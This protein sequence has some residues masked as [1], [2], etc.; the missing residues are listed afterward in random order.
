MNISV[1][2]IGNMGRAVA[3]ALLSA[4]HRVTVFNRSID[5]AR[6]LEKH[7]A[8]VASSAAD[9]VRRSDHI[10]LVLA[11]GASTRSVL[12]D[13]EVVVALF[14]KALITGAGTEPDLLMSLAEGVRAAGA[15]LSDILIV[16]YPQDVEAREA[17]YC[18]S[19]CSE[20]LADWKQ[21]FS[22]IGSRVMD[23]G[24]VGNA[25]RVQTSIRYSFIHMMIA[26]GSAAAAFERQNLPLEVLQVLL[27]QCPT[28][29]IGGSE[30]LPEM[31]SRQYKSNMWTVDNMI[32]LLDAVMESAAKLH[33]DASVIEAIRSLYCRTAAKG[34]G[35]KNITAMYEVLSP[36]VV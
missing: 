3:L 18:V 4:G 26:V 13:P 5:K 9:A 28:L 23:V 36:A 27:S 30:F 32:T 7:G 2:G 22:D 25:Q 17:T 19:A 29:A 12:D 20:D 14:G 11:D 15:R 1:I 33:L 34:F 24:A 21:I 8:V 16:G 31:I 6:A 10:I 35:S